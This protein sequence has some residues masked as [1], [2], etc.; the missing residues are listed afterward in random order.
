MQYKSKAKVGF[1]TVGPS[2]YFHNLRASDNRVIDPLKSQVSTGLD[3]SPLT[4]YLL[5]VD[6]VPFIRRSLL[7][8]VDQLL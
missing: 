4:Y 1:P 8:V 5:D 7:R 6:R 3:L 2:D